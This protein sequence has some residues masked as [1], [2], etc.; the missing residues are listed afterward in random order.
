MRRTSWM[1]SE[2][3]KAFIAVYRKIRKARNDA[4]FH[5]TPPGVLEG[6]VGSEWLSGYSRGAGYA[7]ELLKDFMYSV[8][9][10]SEEERLLATY[11]EDEEDD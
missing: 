11:A 2:E 8:A 4:M 9:E 10:I 6:S 1:T 7:F 3:K 5:W